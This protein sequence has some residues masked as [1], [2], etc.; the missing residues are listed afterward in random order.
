MATRQAF[1]YNGRPSDIPASVWHG[2]TG[3]QRQAV[4]KGDWWPETTWLETVEV[5][6]KRHRRT[7]AE[8]LAAEGHIGDALLTAIDADTDAESAEDDA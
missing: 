4:E 5:S 1:K 3:Q 6:P 2:L 7:K 8:M